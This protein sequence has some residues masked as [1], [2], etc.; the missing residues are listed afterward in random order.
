MFRYSGGWYSSQ[1][2]YRNGTVNDIVCQFQDY[3]R[4]SR[5]II[6]LFLINIKKCLILVLLSNLGYKLNYVGY[7]SGIGH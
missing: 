2:I 4:E 5:E 1:L 6:D 7:S 3:S